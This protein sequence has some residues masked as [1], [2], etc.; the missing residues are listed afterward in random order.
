MKNSRSRLQR[1]VIALVFLLA[2][3]WAIA[4]IGVAV[5]LD[6]ERVFGPYSIIDDAD[7][8]NGLVWSRY[9]MPVPSRVVLNENGAAN[10][11]GRPTTTLNTTSGLP[12][13]TWGKKNGGAFDI[14]VSRFEQGAWTSPLVLASAVTSL[15]DPEPQMVVDK[16]NGDVHVVYF[17]NDATPSVFHRQAPASNDGLAAENLGIHGYAFQ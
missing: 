3:P 5:D 1:S 2:S 8:I 15:M 4:E 17:V 13:V 7:P 10:G 12:L 16:Q 9:S 6:N 14:V 11:D